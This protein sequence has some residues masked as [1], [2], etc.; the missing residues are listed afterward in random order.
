VADALGSVSVLISSFLIHYY[1]LTIA[2]P[3]A[4]LLISIMILYSVWPVLQNSTSTLI[5]LLPNNLE[6]KKTKIENK[7]KRYNVRLKT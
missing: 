2:D 5:H 6:R 1:G 3:I 7:V 4:S